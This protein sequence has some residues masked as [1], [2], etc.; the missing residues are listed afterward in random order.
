MKALNVQ[1]LECEDVANC[2][3]KLVSRKMPEETTDQEKNTRQ[4]A[5]SLVQSV[6]ANELLYGKD[7]EENLIAAHQISDTQIRL[8]KREAGR[9]TFR[10]EPFYPFF[11]FFFFLSKSGLS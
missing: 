6:L 4:D 9:V 2:N 10:D 8:Y 11:F 3:S 5:E 1:A 7:R